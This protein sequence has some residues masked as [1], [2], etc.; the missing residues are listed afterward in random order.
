MGNTKHAFVL[1][2]AMISVALFSM[3]IPIAIQ[4]N[5]VWRKI[6]SDSNMSILL[7]SAYV[8]IFSEHIARSGNLD[9][10]IS[11]NLQRIFSTSTKELVSVGGTRAG[12]FD[13]IDFRSSKISDI[14]R[15]RPNAV[16]EDFSIVKTFL[17]LPANSVAT[18]VEILGN[19]LFI[20][21]DSTRQL[22]PDLYIYTLSPDKN[23][24]QKA[25]Y[26]TGS[27][28]SSLYVD[29]NTLFGA[30]QS[31][32]FPL[33]I[34]SISPDGFIEHATSTVVSSATTTSTHGVGTSLTKEG[35]FLFLGTTKS[36]ISELHV[37][38]ISNPLLPI[39]RNE[40][41]IGT[42]IN[43]LRITNNGYLLIATPESPQIRSISVPDV[44]DGKYNV[45]S[46]TNF[47]GS[48][49]QDA[50]SLYVTGDSI[51]VGRT[52]GGF[53]NVNNPE[54]VIID[55]NDLSLKNAI[56]VGSS[57]QNVI[58]N[59]E[60]LLVA[61]GKPKNQFRLYR[62]IDIGIGHR[63]SL[64]GEISLPGPATSLSC[65]EETIVITLGERSAKSDA[66]VLISIN[67]TYH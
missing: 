45:I 66:V 58:R 25:Q 38:E 17:E 8:N 27:G 4:V 30:N 48:S 53:N 9:I 12:S 39:H 42:Q 24:F 54:I 1:V 40:F 36:S 51:F 60:V 44:I 64:I 7:S 18:D 31:T 65:D 35:S 23:I 56:D 62:I 19:M 67:E 15:I 11:E 22:D 46:S 50:S 37:F 43:D 34:F 47:P 49:V 16:I 63:V 20:S 33:Q 13:S 61:T 21:V 32:K 5:T 29:G 57:V 55:R 28:I 52:V 26:D 14:C 2:D 10:H 59:G 6:E 3:L 41:E